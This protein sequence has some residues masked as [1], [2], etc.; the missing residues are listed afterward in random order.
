[1]MLRCSGNWIP[2]LWMRS[3][4]RRIISYHPVPRCT[5]GY[6]TYVVKIKNVAAGEHLADQLEGTNGASTMQCVASTESM[7]TLA[8]VFL[9]LLFIRL[10]I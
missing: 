8:Y 2:F 4:D 9:V 7:T 3:Y 6:E 10:T 5:A 1:M